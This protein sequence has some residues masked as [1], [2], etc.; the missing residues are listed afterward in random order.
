MQQL[1]DNELIEQV[2]RGNEGS[3]ATLVRRHQR[4]VFTL[5]L[6]FTRNRENAEE[7]AQDVFVKAHPSSNAFRR[8]SRFSTWLYSIA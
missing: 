7:I 3:S 2:L 4:Y 1:P 5:A 6:R 8:T